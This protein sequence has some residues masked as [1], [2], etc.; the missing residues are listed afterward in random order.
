MLL[1]DLTPSA[2]AQELLLFSSSPLFFLEPHLP[3]QQNKF[4]KAQEGTSLVAQWWRV[5]LPMQETQVRFLVR[6]DPT[7]CRAAEPAPQL[8]SLHSG[9]G[10]ETPDEPGL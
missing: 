1:R 3:R 9:G 6:E 10:T 4:I 7:C 5:R 8:P 2:H